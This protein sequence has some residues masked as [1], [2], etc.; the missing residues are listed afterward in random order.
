MA[1]YP[2]YVNAYGKLAALFAKIR[3]AQTPPK[4]TQDYL[5]TILGFKSSSHRAYPGLLKRLG[6]LDSANVPTQD[7]RDYRDSSQSKAIMAKRIKASFPTLFS[8][9]EYA[10]KLS[11]T[12]QTNNVKRITGLGD[13]SPTLDAI[14]GTFMALCALADF[15]A[16][17]PDKEKEKEKE[18]EKAPLEAK[19]SGVNLSYTVVLN[20]PPTT[21]IEV[22]N[23]IFK[24]LRENILHE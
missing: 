11:K 21:D 12:E 3:E 7:Y 14:V 16:T 5:E 20:L 22:F 17:P 23:A 15:K 24:S 8:A 9:N 13:D 2:P 6:F 18:K 10:Y 1:E 4:F 19:P